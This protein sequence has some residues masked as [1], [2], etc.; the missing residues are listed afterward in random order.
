MLRD[1]RASS[2]EAFP[3]FVILLIFEIGT[4]SRKAKFLYEYKAVRDCRCQIE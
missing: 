2:S 4:V 3:N 1:T